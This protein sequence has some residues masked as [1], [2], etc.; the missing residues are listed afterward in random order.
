MPSPENRTAWRRTAETL[1]AA[2]AT[3]VAALIAL[4]LVNRKPQPSGRPLTVGDTVH[5][6][7]IAGG[8]FELSGVA[9][10]PNSNQILVLDDDTPGEIFLVEVGA[11]TTQTGDAIP[12]ALGA[13]VTDMEGITFDGT[14]YYVVGSQSKPTGFEGVGLVRFRYDPVTRRISN[15]ETIAGLKAWLADNVAELQGTAREIGDHVLNI[16]ALAWDPIGQRLLLGLRA[17][18]VDGHALV[19]PIKLVDPALPFSRDNIRADGPS[20]RVDLECTDSDDS[21]CSVI[22]QITRSDPELPPPALTAVLAS[23]PEFVHVGVMNS[24]N[25]VEQSLDLNDVHLA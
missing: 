15:A 22:H 1:I 18:V 9:H 19:V 11:D 4:A 2:V 3:I 5:H 7:P 17:P 12:I 16:E 24:A 10:V 25:A 8:D 13:D 20:I 21:A 23:P 6:R 14:S